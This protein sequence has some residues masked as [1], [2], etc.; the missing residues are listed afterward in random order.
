MFFIFYFYIGSEPN[1]QFLKENVNLKFNQ[2]F[3]E[4]NEKFQTSIPNI[5][6][7][8]D[9]V[10]YPNKLFDN[11]LMNSGHWQSAQI[12]GMCLFYCSILK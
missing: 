8:G 10:L 4:V 9:V 7:G 6:A 1:T 5:Y 2:N 3:I 12:H 11:E